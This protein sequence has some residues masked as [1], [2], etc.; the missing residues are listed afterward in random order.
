MRRIAKVVG[1]QPPRLQSA[2]W[3]TTCQLPRA[4]LP[5]RPALWTQQVSLPPWMTT[6]SSARSN[7]LFCASATVAQLW[8]PP[9]TVC[10]SSRKPGKLHSLRVAPSDPWRPVCLRSVSRILYW[11]RTSALILEHWKAHINPK[12]GSLSWKSLNIRGLVN[13][14]EA[15]R[16]P[17]GQ[18]R[19]MEFHRFPLSPAVS[20]D[21]ESHLKVGFE[22]VSGF[23]FRVSSIETNFRC[24]FR[25]S[26]FRVSSLETNFRCR[27]R[28]SGYKFRRLKPTFAVGFGFRVSGFVDWNQLSLSVSGF[29]FRRLKP[30]F[31]VGFGFRV[32]GFVDWNQ[33]SLSVSG[34]GFRVSSI[35]TNFR[36]RVSGFGFRRLQP[37]FVVGFGFRVS[38]F[39]DWNQLSLSVS[40]FGFRRLKPTFAVGFRVSGFVDWSQLSLSVSGFGFRVSSIAQ[41]T[42][43]VGFGFW[44]SSIETNFRWR[45]R[46][47]G[48]VAWNFGCRVS[49]FVDCNQLSLSV[50]GFGFR[51]SS[52]E[53]NFR[54]RFR[55]SGFVVWIRCRFRVLGFTGFAV[56]NQILGFG[57]RV[58]IGPG[59]VKSS[60]SV[61]GFGFRSSKPTLQTSLRI[62]S[63]C[64]VC[65]PPSTWCCIECLWPVAQP[66]VSSAALPPMNGSGKRGRRAAAGAD[67]D[68]DALAE[69]EEEVRGRGP[70]NGPGRPSKAAGKKTLCSP[71]GCFGRASCQTCS[72][73]SVSSCWSSWWCGHTCR[74]AAWGWRW[75]SSSQETCCQ[76]VFRCIWRWRCWGQT[77]RLL[78]RFRIARPAL[79]GHNSAGHHQQMVIWARQD[80]PSQ[81]VCAKTKEWILLWI[82]VRILPLQNLRLEGLCS[83]APSMWNVVVIWAYWQGPWTA[84]AKSKS[85]PKVS[86]LPTTFAVDRNHR[87]PWYPRGNFHSRTG[88]PVHS[89][90]DFFNVLEF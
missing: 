39:V 42:F 6:L 65:G 50:S 47:S 83:C 25:V 63:P 16:K 14:K 19:S 70:G 36:C 54:C 78:P 57:F 17:G 81:G 75:Q 69:E 18:S 89:L 38:G 62:T 3:S 67:E 72:S 68:V 74:D 88:E 61:S 43:A 12:I 51:V 79:V 4:W 55:V 1:V 85:W 33:L 84:E 8:M 2:R 15:R 66:C 10:M 73:Q 71:P 27:F 64:C 7:I 31:A 37:T 52:L 34:F 82:E 58:S 22:S 86:R 77:P 21:P 23:G 60:E 9:F 40:G 5:S 20:S 56:R 87:I 41:P 44:V 59:E 80:F 35:E 45:F 76:R 53:T 90:N 49:G 26:G 28:V 32:T 30:T 13:V 29:G 11:N 24:R 48:F 46:V